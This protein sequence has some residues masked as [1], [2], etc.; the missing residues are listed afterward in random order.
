[1]PKEGKSGA[2]GFDARR[3]RTGSR[4]VRIG[5]L[6]DKSFV[7]SLIARSRPDAFICAN[8]HTAAQL[9]R[10]LHQNDV[11]VPKDVRVVGFD[12]VNFATLVSPALTTAR[13]PCK[14]LASAAFH[15]MLERQVEPN[16]PPRHMMIM[17]Q[18]VVRES[19]GPWCSNDEAA[20][21]S[22]PTERIETRSKATR[23]RYEVTVVDSTNSTSG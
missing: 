12:D 6:D 17:P 16:L 11:H 7:R 19:S 20:V 10:A 8:D 21:E 9:L 5:A 15:A 1:M 22:S 14:E 2:L 23:Q 4:L 3:D 18:L 13:Q